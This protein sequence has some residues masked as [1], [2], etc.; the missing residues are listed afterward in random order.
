MWLIDFLHL[1]V[2]VLELFLRLNDQS[3]NKINQS[4]EKVFIPTNAG[5][6]CGITFCSSTINRFSRLTEH[7]GTA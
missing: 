2:F 4:V 3:V 6:E 5:T 7:V 1:C